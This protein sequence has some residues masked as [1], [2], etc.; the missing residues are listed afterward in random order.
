[1]LTRSYS[2]IRSRIK[3]LACVLQNIRSENV[4]R[5]QPRP[6]TCALNLSSWEIRERPAE[7]NVI[8]MINEERRKKKRITDTTYI[9][10]E[11][12]SEPVINSGQTMNSKFFCGCK[13]DT[14]GNLILKFELTLTYTHRMSTN[15]SNLDDISVVF[16]YWI[17]IGPWLID[18]LIRVSEG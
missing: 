9:I 15:A 16:A 13:N 12:C 1:M 5:T 8:V 18:W 6:H 17:L 2:T 11:I 10:R 4:F 7:K 14:L 3:G